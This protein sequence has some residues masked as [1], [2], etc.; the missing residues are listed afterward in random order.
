[1]KRF[2]LPIIATMLFTCIGC[3]KEHEAP[4]RR[5]T[6][7]SSLT[8]VNITVPG[9]QWTEGVRPNVDATYYYANYDV[10]AI[11]Q[12]VIDNGFVVAYIYN[13]Y[14]NRNQLGSWNELP[15]VYPYI[16]YNQET[17]ERYSVG[18]NIRFEWELGKVTFVVEDIDGLLPD[19]LV[20]TEFDFKVC[21][22][23]N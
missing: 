14:D 15:Y 7:S 18:E 12:E 1:M 21:V 5:I 16:F 13:I 10:P 4:A 11:T 20:D 3:T 6:E 9:T 8:V 2:L 23:H 19:A 17:G 22:Y